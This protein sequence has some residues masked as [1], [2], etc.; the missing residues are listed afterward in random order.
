MVGEKVRGRWVQVNE[1]MGKT[2]HL[3]L[4]KTAIIEE[5]DIQRSDMIRLDF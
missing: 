3:I 1:T 2:L 4:R 5:S